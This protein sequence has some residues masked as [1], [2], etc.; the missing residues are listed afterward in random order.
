MDKIEIPDPRTSSRTRVVE[1]PDANEW[2]S[3]YTPA[4]ALAI[5]LLNSHAIG[6]LNDACRIANSVEALLKPM[7]FTVE[8]TGV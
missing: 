1:V 7:G 6:T 8:F 3:P 5:A 4:Q 2:V